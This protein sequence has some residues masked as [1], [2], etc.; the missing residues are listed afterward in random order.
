VF[1]GLALALSAA[2]YVPMTGF[3]PISEV[4]ATVER[5]EP[6]TPEAAA[7]EFPEYGSSAIGAIGFPGTLAT[8]GAAEPMP[9][10][11]IT[12]IVTAL[13]VLDVKPLAADEP[14]PDITFSAKDVGFYREALAQNGSVKSVRNGMTL[15]QR[16]LLE[17]VLIASANNYAMSLANWAYGS[18]DAYLAAAR[19]WLDA[20]GLAS[21][22]V[23]DA[24]GLSAANTATASDLVALGKLA[25]A[26]PVIA[27]ITSTETAT[28]PGIGAIKNTNTLL[29]KYGVDGIKTG[30]LD[31]AGACLLFSADYT[32]GD[33]RVTVVG[34]V[35]GAPDHSTLSKHVRTLLT[36]VVDGFHEV[37][38][39]SKGDE[40]VSYST[41]WG[42]HAAGV[43][44]ETATALTWSDTPISMLVSA[45]PLSVAERG[46][47]VGS[48]TFTAGERTVI[49][50]IDL[51]DTLDDP[52]FWWRL[53][54]PSEVL[55]ASGN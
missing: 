21:V 37:T 49:V 3:A 55:G 36:S 42:D 31:E 7:L 32:V 18:P 26:N 27:E 23:T 25:I 46:T 5:F 16:Q 22:T 4:R 10:A 1:G 13:V 11:S 20:H 19:V 28:E 14:G 38:L 41:K 30:T 51:D 52:G 12:K 15:T 9:I 44:A 29:G 39:V 40:L 50:P 43:A 2:V 47:E 48:A 53:T 6:P 17:T 24:T 54:H 34:A 35:L 8:S 45:R 33:A